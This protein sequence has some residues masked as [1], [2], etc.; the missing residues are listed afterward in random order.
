MYRVVAPFGRADRIGAAGITGRGGERI[1]APLAVGAAD[2]VDRREIEDIETERG[3]FRQPGDA[4]VE[5]AVAAGKAALAARHHFVPGAGAG[6]R[7]V[8]HQRILAR[9]G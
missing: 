8:H 5:C 1:V 2:R 3:D 7:P 6:D 9:C 4:I